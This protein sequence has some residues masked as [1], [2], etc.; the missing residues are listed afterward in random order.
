MSGLEEKLGPGHQQIILGLLIF[1]AGA[2]WGIMLANGEDTDLKDLFVSAVIMLSGA[3]I[4]LLGIS[5]GTDN[6]EDRTNDLQDAIS[7]LT[8]ML[9]TLQAKVTGSSGE[10]E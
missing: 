5:F 9:N 6:E 1:A 7:E 10:E 2:L 3:M 8:G 4:T